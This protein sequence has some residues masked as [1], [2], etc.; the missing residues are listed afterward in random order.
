MSL[1]ITLPENFSW[2][3]NCDTTDVYT[4]LQNNFVQNDNWRMC[5]SVTSIQFLLENGIHIGIYGTTDGVARL[6]GFVYGLPTKLV[7]NS[8]EHKVLFCNLLC[9]HR[10]LRGRKMVHVLT[11][12]L[13]KKA[14]VLGYFEAIYTSGTQL[15]S[16]ARNAGNNSDLFRNPICTLNYYVLPL[17]RSLLRSHI[18]R[19]RKQ[20]EFRPLIEEDIEKACRLLNRYLENF[21][22]HTLFDLENFK[23]IFLNGFVETYV[24]DDEKEITDL[25]SF[26]SI[27]ACLTEGKEE[28]TVKVAYLYHYVPGKVSITQLLDNCIDTIKDMDCDI[29]NVLNNGRINMHVLAALNF[30]DCECNL[31]YYSHGIEKVTVEP[32]MLGVWPM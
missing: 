20:T 31:H 8:V 23:K 11:R 32:N 3:D 25:F 24:R 22:I 17:K 14:A 18:T 26:Y 1:E 21:V 5:Y 2:N 13:A 4:F 19:I 16:G 12:S 15:E 7:V 10:K 29:F 30:K 6:V 28:K 27:D 9:V